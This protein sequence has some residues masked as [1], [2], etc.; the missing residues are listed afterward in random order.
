MYRLVSLW[1]SE[2]KLNYRHR[3]LVA[4][5]GFLEVAQNHVLGCHGR[6]P[7][8]LVKTSGAL[9]EAAFAMFVARTKRVQ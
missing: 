3:L 9:L 8:G 7:D 5:I 2:E 6:L 1:D 4:I